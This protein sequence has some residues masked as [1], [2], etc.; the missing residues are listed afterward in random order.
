MQAPK[1]VAIDLETQ[2]LEA[3][4]K[5]DCKI[6]S[7]SI[8]TDASEG[9]INLTEYE[10]YED[11]IAK[12]RD[13]IPQLQDRGYIPCFHNASFDKAVLETNGIRIPEWHD[14]LVMSYVNRPSEIQHHKLETLARLVGETK[15]DKPDFH[16]PVVDKKFL[17]YNL[18]DSRITY[19]L[20]YY[21]WDLLSREPSNLAWYVNYERWYTR[22]IICMES[23]TLI[24]VPEVQRLDRV[25]T[26]ELE[27]L[28]SDIM[29]NTIHQRGAEVTYKKQIFHLDVKRETA[30]QYG[31]QVPYMTTFTGTY[32]H[33]T[34]GKTYKGEH[35]PVAFFNPNS[36]AEIAY[37]LETLYDWKPRHFNKPTKKYPNGAPAFN[38]KVKA[39]LRHKYPLVESLC[40]WDELSKF[41]NTFV[42][43]ALLGRVNDKNYVYA[44]FNQCNTRTGR[45]SSSSPN[46][47]NVPTRSA[48]GKELRRCFIAPP[49]YKIVCGDVDRFELRIL[50]AYLE[51][52]VG[53]SYLAEA[54]RAGLDEHTI[55]TCKWFGVTQDDPQFD[56]L[57][58]RAKNGI[59]TV[60][61]GGGAEKLAVTLGVT[62]QQ[63]KDIIQAIRDTTR[64]FQLK[65][66]VAQHCK[67][68]SG[69]IYDWMGR[70]LWVPELL[71]HDKS[72]YAAGYR[73]VNNYI[74]QGSQGSIFKRLQL[75]LDWHIWQD[76]TSDIDYYQILSVHDEAVYVVKEEH[77]DAF[78]EAANFVFNRNDILVYNGQY[79]PI[80]ASFHSGDNWYDAKSK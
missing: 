48:L 8:V 35:C 69:V 70:K 47:Q 3:R 68:N 78:I 71:S 51:S 65:E 66:I 16:N 42:R 10:D 15:Y 38:K 22:N 64:I 39:E 45:L 33:D 53:D 54:G 63:A 9:V 20:F 67:R 49:G 2:G 79:V 21:L 36:D 28:D 11:A 59:F 23:G 1:I 27:T 13:I 37:Q 17:S 60:V 61:Y 57:R 50:A 75:E 43:G 34:F 41:R 12:L 72:E 46:F 5:L 77:T 25:V 30:A 74:I 24:D 7:V 80:T 58:P 44:G 73:R 19:K 31:L 62:V 76:R 55:N 29:R 26:E 32:T 6:L 4:Y 14:T 56:T 40:R 52:I 18:Q